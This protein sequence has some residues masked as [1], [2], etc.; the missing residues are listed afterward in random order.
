MSITSTVIWSIN[1]GQSH[2]SLSLLRDTSYLTRAMPG[3]VTALLPS[4]VTSDKL[5]DL[6]QWFPTHDTLDFLNWLAWIIVFISGLFSLAQALLLLS[7]HSISQ[8]LVLKREGKIH[9]KIWYCDYWDNVHWLRC[10]TPSEHVVFASL[11][12]AVSYISL[13]SVGRK[14]PSVFMGSV[15]DIIC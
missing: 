10:W 14:L 6:S 4:W 3:Q 8:Y 7:I 11:C 15:T 13:F 9:R 2:Q 5:F 12:V 1:Q